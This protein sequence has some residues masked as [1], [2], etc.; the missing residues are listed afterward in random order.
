MITEDTARVK[1]SHITTHLSVCIIHNIIITEI[2]ADVDLVLNKEESAVPHFLYGHSMGGEVVCVY[3]CLYKKY[4]K[5]PN[6]RGVI[7]SAPYVESGKPLPKI[8]VLQP[9]IARYYRQCSVQ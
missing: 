4:N 3:M 8:K 2:L 1:A 9:L 6:F 7:V 5:A